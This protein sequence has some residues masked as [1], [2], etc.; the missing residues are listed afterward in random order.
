MIAVHTHIYSVKRVFFLV[1][2]SNS[3]VIVAV[4]LFVNLLT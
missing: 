3:C 4:W 1:I 2:R